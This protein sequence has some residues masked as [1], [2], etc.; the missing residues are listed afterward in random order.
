M[1]DDLDIVPTTPTAPPKPGLRKPE[2]LIAL[3][4]YKSTNPLTAFSVMGLIDRRRTAIVLN[5]GDA[6]VVHSRNAVGDAFL[7]SKH[8]WMLTIDDDMVVPFGNGKWF[9][10]MTGMKI[11]EPF[12]N[13]NALDRLMSH[14]KT[15]VGALYFGRWKHGA[16]MFAEGTRDSQM[17]LFS[18]HGP[19]DRLQPT[20][21]VGTGCMLIH[22]SVL[23]DIEKT[24]PNLARKKEGGTKG[25]QWFTSTEHQMAADLDRALAKM[26]GE[27]GTIDP[28]EVL[29][30]CSELHHARAKAKNHSALGQGEDVSFCIRAAQAGHQ[31]YVDFGL[32]CG[33]VGLETYGPTNTRPV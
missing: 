29:K 20:R 33:H 19:H 31:P 2:V 1:T 30:V 25:G 26:M 4:W 28:N 32:V 24:F 9:N 12:C 16:P 13:F 17:A 21:W 8:E 14:G 15:L 3:P 11:P 23:E 22:R 18:R 7:K 6:F 5:F 27:G 10:A